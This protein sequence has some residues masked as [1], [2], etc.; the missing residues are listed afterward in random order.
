MSEEKRRTLAEIL[1]AHGHAWSHTG[2]LMS[3][4]PADDTPCYCGQVT[5]GDR[6]RQI[7]APYQLEQRLARVEAELS[8][9]RQM[10]EGN[11]A[12]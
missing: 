11:R 10:Y 6:R 1:C 9:L 8:R 7:T 12:V 4:E 5:W 2:T 3:T